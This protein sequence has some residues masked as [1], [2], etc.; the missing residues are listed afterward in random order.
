MG[1][2]Y[3]SSKGFQCCKLLELEVSGFKSLQHMKLKTPSK[4]TILVGPNGSGKT[5]IIESLLL[6]RDIVDYIRG[7]IIN[8][9]LRWWGYYHIVWKHDETKPIRLSITL[10]C[11]ACNKEVLKSY[12]DSLK[13]I[14]VRHINI[15]RNYRIKYDVHVTGTGGNFQVLMD[16]ICIENIACLTA[17]QGKLILNIAKPIKTFD[18][19]IEPILSS[20]PIVISISIKKDIP[21]SIKGIVWNCYMKIFD[22][23][24]RRKDT[25]KRIINELLKDYMESKFKAKSNIESIL[26]IY[27]RNET[28]A[29]FNKFFYDI[30]TEAEKTT[31]EKI[32]KIVHDLL[33]YCHKETLFK[34][35]TYYDIIEEIITDLT[36]HS[37]V[38]SITN[39]M[40]ELLDLAI[41]MVGLFI[42]NIVILRLLD[43]SSLRSP[44]IL[45]PP[46]R[47]REDGTNLLSILFNLGKGRLPEDIAVV[48]ADVLHGTA[49]S[50]FFEPTSDG[51]ITFRLIVDNIDISQPAIPEG[52]W[53]TMAIMAAILS[54]ASVIAIDEFENSLHASAQELLLE[55]L[56]NNVPNTI[57]ATHSPIVVDAAKSLDEIVIVE[58]QGNATIAKRIE[59]SDKL[60]EKLK[61]LGITPSE[62]LLYSL[63]ET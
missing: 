12:K 27:T 63:L 29:R 60:I 34:D 35:K 47:L 58:L 26:S 24:I 55:E 59:K 5:A 42:D 57:I 61:K 4:L 19:I 32:R 14:R 49:V 17:K 46:S 20:M 53:K 21:T 50:G 3:M 13:Q 7:R 43:Y 56:R 11:N 30:K 62:A 23:L 8:P 44:Q 36:I 9:F 1:K 15:I 33:P 10:D 38:F 39:Y 48:L 54:G 28:V 52:A 45:E 16:E 51:R 37:I 40:L 22:E 31:R 41:Y 25:L 6:L 2:D 18:E